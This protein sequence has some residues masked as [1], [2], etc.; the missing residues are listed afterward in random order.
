MR[1]DFFC[2]L[3]A[4][5]VPWA[6]N[7]P[8][9]SDDVSWEDHF[10]ALEQS[11]PTRIRAHISHI[12]LLH[13]SK[14]ES[15]ID[16]LQR[17]S[18]SDASY[19]RD[20]GAVANGIDPFEDSADTLASFECTA[21]GIRT[22][23]NSIDLYTTEAMEASRDYGYLCQ[24]EVDGERDMDFEAPPVAFIGIR[25]RAF[26][27]AAITASKVARTI[28]PEMQNRSTIPPNLRTHIQH[29]SVYVGEAVTTATTQAII[30]E[31][32]LNSEQKRAFHIITEH[33]SQPIDSAPQLLMGIFGE[34]G[35]GKSR[36][37][38]AL[39][40]WFSIVGR[41]AEIRVTAMTGSAASHIRGSTLHS[42]TGIKVEYGER[43]INRGSISK[44]AA[45]WC[46][47]RYLIVDEVSMIDRDI[48]IRLE[49]QLRL[50][51]SNAHATLGG[52]NIIFCGDFLQF[53]SCS[54]LNVYER[55]T[56]LEFTEGYDLWRSIN[57]VVILRRQMRQWDDPA[58]ASLLQRIRM[59][60]PTDEDIAALISRIGAPLCNPT[61]SDPPAIIV[62]RHTVRTAFNNSKIEEAS[63]NH[64]IP[65]TYCVADIME[66]TQMHH[67]EI[68]EITYPK[69]KVL[70]DAVLAL[71][72]GVPLMITKNIEIPLGMPHLLINLTI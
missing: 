24:P 70:A 65:I 47:T 5:F 22:F 43:S 59:R 34:G 58:W 35:T 61:D 52:M 8:V 69:G 31:Y 28:S 36:L 19:I 13:K 53:P 44:K 49:V 21:A 50:L 64:N 16:Q 40:A 1:N 30:S 17:P 2:L 54:G 29:P 48:M 41:G 42:A 51:T 37:I 15:I 62:R 18:L 20:S 67:Q 9:K 66:K 38:D 12:E 46:D 10:T 68:Y 11:L 63:E 71:V 23:Q 60:C 4:L 33:A 25:S 32:S 72:P 3:T 26:V 57:S 45:E 14:E 6:S 56:S 7:V 27:N 55:G 39:R